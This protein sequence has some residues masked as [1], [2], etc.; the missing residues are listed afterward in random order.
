MK[1]IRQ[2]KTVI[3]M[4]CALTLMYGCA[5][6]AEKPAPRGVDVTVLC[7]VSKTGVK[8]DD[9]A[10]MVEYGGK[11]YYFCCSSC[12]KEFEKNPEKYLGR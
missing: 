9:S 2:I 7:P 10:Q 12:K 6:T 1:K 8:A 11:K 4:V 5:A 3:A